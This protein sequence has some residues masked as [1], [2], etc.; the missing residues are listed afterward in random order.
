MNCTTSS[1]KQKWQKSL[2]YFDK[3]ELN[4]LT[5]CQGTKIKNKDLGSLKEKIPNDRIIEIRTYIRNVNPI[6]INYLTWVTRKSLSKLHFMKDHI[7]SE[8]RLYISDQSIRNNEE[9][10]K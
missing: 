3:I 8:V 7:S 5:N 4:K 9:L 6:Y 1:K 2:M 10:K